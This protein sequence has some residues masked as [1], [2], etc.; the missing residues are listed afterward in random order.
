M[1]NNLGQSLAKKKEFPIDFSGKKL[2]LEENILFIEKKSR[3]IGITQ[4]IYF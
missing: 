4:C 3:G 2:V 1:D